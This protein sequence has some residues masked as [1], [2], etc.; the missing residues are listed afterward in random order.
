MTKDNL[1]TVP[2]GT[3]LEQ[4]KEILHR[5][6]VEKLLVVDKDFNLKGLITVKDIQK[7][8]KYPNACKDSLGRLRVGAALGRDRPTCSS[9]RPPSSRPRWTWW[10][11]TPP[12]AT[13]AGVHGHGA[14]P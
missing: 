9:A 1:I 8:I 6:K 3:T 12:T 13:P 5:H 14:R 11:W 2:V 10:W 4:A 7:Q